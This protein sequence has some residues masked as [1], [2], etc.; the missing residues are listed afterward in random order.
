MAYENLKDLIGRTESDKILR[1]K[2]F[3][4]GK[5]RDMME[6]NVDLLQWSRNFFDKKASGNGI[7][8]DNISNEEL[9]EESQKPTTK[10]S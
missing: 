6:I 1:D 3:N 5:I 4:I 2:V 9:A 8:N 10:K 7:K